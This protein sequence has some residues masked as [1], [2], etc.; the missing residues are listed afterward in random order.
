MLINLGSWK[1]ILDQNR[2]KSKEEKERESK[3]EERRKLMHTKYSFTKRS[4]IS[5]KRIE[6][7][8][9][10]NAGKVSSLNVSESGGGEL[11]SIPRLS[12]HES[13]SP[14]KNEA[15]QTIDVLR[16]VFSTIK[17]VAYCFNIYRKSEIK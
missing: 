6:E 2:E 15:F 17:E 13:N 11:R 1:A 16:P 5:P 10:A 9:L 8:H 4:E 12:T 3:L 14:E 7:K